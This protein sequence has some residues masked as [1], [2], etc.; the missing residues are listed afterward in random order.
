MFLVSIL[1]GMSIC[2]DLVLFL[3]W[4]R[5]SC[6][7][8]TKFGKYLRTS[9]YVNPVHYWKNPLSMESIHVDVTSMNAEACRY[10]ISSVIDEV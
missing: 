2:V 7:V 6:G 9:L 4:F 5:C 1:I 10:F 8:A 3:V